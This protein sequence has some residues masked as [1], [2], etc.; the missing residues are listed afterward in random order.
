[1]K[2]QVI[3]NVWGALSSYIEIDGRRIVIDL[4]K[5]GNFSPVSDFLLPL[6]RLWRFPRQNDGRYILDQ[7]FLSHLDNDHIADVADFNEHF[8]P[9]Y[10]TAPSDN[11][12]QSNHFHVNRERIKNPGEDYSSHVLEVMRQLT[13]GYWP[14]DP[15]WPDHPLISGHPD[16]ISLYYIPPRICETHQN[17]QLSNYANNISLVL[18]INIDGHTTLMPW[19]IMPDG[20][21]YLLENYPDLHRQMNTLGVDF[22]L[23]PHHWLSS[24]FSPRLFQSMKWGKTKRLNII[25]EKT[26]YSD[27]EENRTPVDSRYYNG[28][29][30]QWSNNLNLYGTKTSTGHI[31]IDYSYWTP[32]VKVCDDSQLLREFSV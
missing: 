6:S 3:F 32:Q 29:Y 22:L 27:S 20:V 28:D 11:P 4:G 30:S 18:F 16:I 15:N 23:A 12:Q 9:K 1:M 2:K 7:V 31:V 17:L 21:E 10:Y 5:S 19:D 24:T 26:R 13:P 8:S 25:S 14:A